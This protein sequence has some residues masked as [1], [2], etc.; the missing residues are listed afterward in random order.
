MIREAAYYANMTL[1]VYRLLRHPYTRSSDMLREQ[2]ALRE[3]RFL[4]TAGRRVFANPRN[5]YHE[6]FRMAGCAPGDLAALVKCRGLEAGPFPTRRRRRLPDRTTNS[7][8]ATPLVRAG[9][10]IAFA[11]AVFLNPV[12]RGYMET[13]SSGSRRPRYANTEE[14]RTTA[15]SRTL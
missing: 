15:L 3:E 10:H 11:P 9:R 5:P 6:L 1:G 12:S 7:R 13:T 8:A 2:M 14:S 4:D